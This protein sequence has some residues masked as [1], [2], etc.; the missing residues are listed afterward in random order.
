MNDPI[1]DY[2]LDRGRRSVHWKGEDYYTIAAVPYYHH[3]R[4]TLVGLLTQDI[5]EFEPGSRVCDFG[6]GDGYYT[7]RF[8]ERFPG[9]E[10]TGVDISDTML[11]KARAL[12]PAMEFR[13]RVSEVE[14]SIDHFMCIGVFTCIVND[15][16][17]ESIIDDIAKKCREGSKLI[18]FEQIA[19]TAYRKPTLVRRPTQWYIDAFARRGLIAKKHQLIYYNMHVLFERFIA[20][21]W[22][23]FIAS[24]ASDHERRLNSNRNRVFLQLSNIFTRL[25]YR[26]VRTPDDRK[27]GYCYLVFEYSPK[28]TA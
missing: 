24:G 3:R 15:Q 11:E 10:W 22:Y 23:R 17:V 21:P 9:L 28:T 20:K 26:T 27:W 13:S 14:G 7:R 12:N 5:S 8:H 19:P 2:W 6:C 16:L 18:L 4:E 1:T 25:S